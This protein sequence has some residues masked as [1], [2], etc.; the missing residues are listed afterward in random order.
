M[1]FGCC[2]ITFC[3]AFTCEL[4]EVPPPPKKLPRRMSLIPVEPEPTPKA[5]KPTAKT[6]ARKTKT[7]FA[8]L[9]RRGKNIVCS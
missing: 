1:S 2:A 8:C 9:R 5:T 7:H 4:V 6:S 3:F